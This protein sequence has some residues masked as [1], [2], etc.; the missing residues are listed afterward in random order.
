MEGTLLGERGMRRCRGCMGH[1]GTFCSAA[2]NL[3]RLQ[4]LVCSTPCYSHPPYVHCISRFCLS[5]R[6][7]CKQTSSAAWGLPLSWP[8]ALHTVNTTPCTGVVVQSLS[9][10][11]LFVTPWAAAHQASLSIT[12]QLQELAQ[13]HAH[14]VCDVI[15]SSHPLLFP[16]PPA[17]NPSQH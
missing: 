17:F 14:W 5:L 11:W 3:K 9:G 16:S 7:S 1:L 13:T 15:L 8:T 10:V 2:V 4:K 12:N 6:D